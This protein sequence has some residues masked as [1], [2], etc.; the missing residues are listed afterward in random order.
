MRKVISVLL[1]VLAFSACDRAEQRRINI[2]V[3]GK[4]TTPYWNDVELGAKAAG[5]RLG[6]SVEFFVPSKEEPASWQLRQVKELAARPV[7]GMAF[8]A[9]DPKTLNPTIL[10]AM[11][12]G[13]PCIAMDTDVGNKNRHVYIGANDYQAGKQAGEELMS[14]LEVKGRIAIVASFSS[15]TASLKRVRGFSD[16]LAHNINV[17][18]VATLEEENNLVQTSDVVSLLDSYPDLDGI[19]YAS[20]SDGIAIGESLKKADKAGR[21]KAVGIGESSDL[22]EYIKSDVIQATVARTP[23]VIGYLAILVLHNMAVV[24]IP[25][26]LKILPESRMIDTGIVLVTR[27]NI[28][29]YREQLTESGAKVSF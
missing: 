11:Q 10:K 7:D 6:V 14:I 2:A 1:I 22:M 26:A 29:Q 20:N 28:P 3:V 13:I 8:S 25:N 19:F 24:G 17:D 15:K 27:E 4:D 23:Y 12:S 16:V 18:I 21:V 5:E 9:F